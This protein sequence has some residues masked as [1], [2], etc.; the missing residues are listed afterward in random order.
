MSDAVTAHD[1]LDTAGTSEP[2]GRR[3]PSCLATPE[4][5]E[6]GQDRSRQAW[7]CP[8]CALIVLDDQL[9]Q[10]PELPERAD[11]R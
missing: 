3:C 9:A 6:L 11:L 10:V 4:P 2:G 7:W 5:T 1:D 8:R